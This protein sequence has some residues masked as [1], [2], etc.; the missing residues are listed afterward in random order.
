MEK[1][2][3]ITLDQLM[4]KAQ[5]R[6]AAE[7]VY[8]EVWCDSLQGCLLLE[9]VPLDRILAVYDASGDGMTENLAANVEAIY[10]S[11]PMLANTALQE[12]Y[13]CA[14]PHDIVRAVLDDNMGDITR[15]VSAIQGFYG[16]DSGEGMVEEVKN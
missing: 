4:A 7:K 15:L 5:Q 9:K 1:G 2:K 6:Q 12:S 11:C 16:M 8:R 3:R 14:E 10:I 13:Q